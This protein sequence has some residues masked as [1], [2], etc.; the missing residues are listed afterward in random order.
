MP[1][2]ASLHF[3]TQTEKQPQVLLT[4]SSDTQ[5][6]AFVS[7]RFSSLDS[8]QTRSHTDR[9]LP[10]SISTSAVLLLRAFCCLSFGNVR[11]L[12]STSLRRDT[13]PQSHRA[14]APASYKPWACR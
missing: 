2:S 12:H 10:S 1:P 7:W 14:T 9:L 8:T 5:L 3:C 4:H 6:L 11:K 13:E